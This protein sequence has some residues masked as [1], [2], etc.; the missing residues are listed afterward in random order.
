MNMK[1]IKK[2][3][4]ITLILLFFVL[5]SPACSW[6]ERSVESHKKENKEKGYA[7]KVTYNQSPLPYDYKALEPY[8]DARTLELHYTKHHAGYV[9]KL[10]EAL[11][12][13]PELLQKSVEEIL[14][15][16]DAVPE[17]IRLAVRNQG[18]GHWVHEFFWRCMRP[19]SFAKSLAEGKLKAK[20]EEQ[21]GSFD[22]FK[23]EFEKSALGLFGS[24]WTWLV[25]DP[26][27][28]KLRIMTTPNHDL[29]QR[30]GMVPLLVLDVWEHAYY[31]K[32]QNRRAEFIEQWW[33]V[34]DWTFVA[35]CFDQVRP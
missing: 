11:E 13:H 23:K 15:H 18:G 33:H 27:I 29:P 7:M 12:K 28:N 35:S 22:A 25:F 20:I 5:M 14:I 24:G 21:F 34:V 32:F 3:Y 2:W 31:L 26:Q 17:D 8:L 10:G 1:F 16:L 19:A 4:S 6:G 30:E 9:K